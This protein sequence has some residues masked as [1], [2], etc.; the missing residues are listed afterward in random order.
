MRSVVTLYRRG[1]AYYAK[2]PCAD[3]KLTVRKSVNAL[4]TELRGI[5]RVRL[6]KP[7]AYS[8]A[9][10]ALE[11]G[12]IF[13]SP[14]S[15]ANEGKAVMVNDYIE[16]IFDYDNSEYIRQKLAAKPN[17]ITRTYCLDTLNGYRKHGA[18]ELKG[19]SLSDF[20]PF[21]AEEVKD[22]LLAKG[23][24]SSTINKVLQALRTAL[25]EAYRKGLIEVNHSPGIVN[26]NGA[27]K[28]RGI[29]TNEEVVALLKHLKAKN[30]P[31]EYDRAGYLIV[32]LAVYTG[33]RQG[34]IRA[35]EVEDVELSDGPESAIHV[36]HSFSAHDGLKCTKSRRERIVPA[37]T[38]LC[39]EVVEYSKLSPNKFIFFSLTRDGKPVST[40]TV[41]RW[42]V[43]GL[44]AIGI[45]EEERMRRFIDFHSLRHFFTSSMNAVLSDDDR[46]KMLGHASITMTD[47]YTHTTPEY[48]KRMGE[49]R[50]KALPYI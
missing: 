21:M 37:P 1:K 33:M 45:S 28:E 11:K 29:P 38:P 22:K 50:G 4:Y 15:A 6:T 20:R 14:E 27:K 43:E 40:E 35:L 18:P 24:S 42:Y 17:S 30:A 32:A 46:R 49:E 8:I 16:Q 13:K 41:F 26:L 12:I 48:V 5:G 44:L 7:Q 23:L 25:G 2:F 9:L 31:G 36:R 10:E 47:H 34:E 19:V 3:G 39:R